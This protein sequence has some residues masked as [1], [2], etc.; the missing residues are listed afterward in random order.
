[1]I[2]ADVD[3]RMGPF[4]LRAGDCVNPMLRPTGILMPNRT[5]ALTFKTGFGQIAAPLRKAGRTAEMAGSPCPF[6]VIPLVVT[7][8]R[9]VISFGQPRQTDNLV[10][11]NRTGQPGS[12]AV[13]PEP[14][15]DGG[16]DSILPV[17]TAVFSGGP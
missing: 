15:F 7:Q 10:D 12:V 2:Q 4:T 1:M 3:R 14:I 17:R 9:G 11:P 6:K 13:Y 5:R 16:T 8:M